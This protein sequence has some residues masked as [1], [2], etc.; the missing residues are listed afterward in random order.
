MSF[1]IDSQQNWILEF[2][3]SG[4]TR[5]KTEASIQSSEVIPF[6]SKGVSPFFPLFPLKREFTSKMKSL[7][8]VF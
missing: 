6:F 5:D 7:P 4:Y 8:S 3:S 1:P 2:P